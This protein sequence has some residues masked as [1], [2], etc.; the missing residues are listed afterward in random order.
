MSVA[1]EEVSLILQP[2]ELPVQRQVVWCSDLVMIHEATLLQFF[3]ISVPSPFRRRGPD[4]PLNLTEALQLEHYIQFCPQD[5]GIFNFK[6]LNMALKLLW[7]A[8]C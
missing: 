4:S 5:E 3:S 8:F 1:K 7:G 2:E 6:S